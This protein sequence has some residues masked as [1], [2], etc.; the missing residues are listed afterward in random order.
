MR[1]NPA[2]CPAGDQ[3]GEGWRSIDD[4]SSDKP[5][6]GS[7]ARAAAPGRGARSGA[8]SSL[9]R[10]AR[11]RRCGGLAGGR[12]G[13]CGG[14]CAGRGAHHLLGLRARPPDHRGRALD[15]PRRPRIRRPGAVR[16]VSQHGSVGSDDGDRPEPV[17]VTVPGR[18]LDRR[19]PDGAA[20]QGAAD[21]ARRV[22]HRGRHRPRQDDRGGAHRL[23][24]AAAT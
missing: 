22:V 24:V 16:R 10:G 3:A 1:K 17:P 7:V 23:G 9:A 13:L 21:A 18:H 6:A 20:A 12:A 14:R 5:R 8:F 15:G 11:G 2:R 19:L 4:D